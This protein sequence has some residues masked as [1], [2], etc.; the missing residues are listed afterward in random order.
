MREQA[1]MR[2][3]KLFPFVCV[4]TGIFWRAKSTV[5]FKCSGKYIEIYFSFKITFYCM[6]LIVRNK[7]SPN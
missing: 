4:F 5:L 1:L 6:Q 7:A 2:D 3:G